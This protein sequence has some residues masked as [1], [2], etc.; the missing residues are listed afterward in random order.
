[1]RLLTVIT[2]IV[3]CGAACSMPVLADQLSLLSSGSA[4]S[5]CSKGDGFVTVS[6][7]G[8]NAGTC[9][10]VSA[11]TVSGGATFDS[12]DGNPLF[13]GTYT[14]GFPVPPIVLGPINAL[15][16][17]PANGITSSFAFNGGTAGSLSGTVTWNFVVD[18]TANPRWDGNLTISTVSGTDTNFLNDFQVN[19][20]NHIDFTMKTVA[21]L[22]TLSTSGGITS[23]NISSGQ[24]E[25]VPEV[26]SL[27]LFGTGMLLALS[28]ISY[29]RKRFSI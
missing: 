4:V 21:F 13:L 15:N 3:L 27:L 19:A 10:P 12:P 26:S 20:V 25:P 11:G 8:F 22:S 5:Y 18:H 28:V 16:E 24:V 7:T 2:G 14:I 17:F 1:M 29:R 23:N 6:A 9:D